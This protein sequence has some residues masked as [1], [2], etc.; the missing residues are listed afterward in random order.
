MLRQSA[1]DVDEA[2]AELQGYLNVLNCLAVEP[3]NSVPDVIIWML[4]ADKRTAYKR[5]PAYD[6]LY[7]EKT[8]GRGR[9]C[10]NLQTLYLEYP[11]TKSD[12]VNESRGVPVQLRIQLWLG[13]DKDQDKFDSQYAGGEI[14]TYAETY[15]NQS[16]V[17]VRG[18]GGCLTRPDFSDLTGKMRLNKD[19]F[20]VF[21]KEFSTPFVYKTF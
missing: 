3:Q 5:I 6:L 16:K 11:M 21:F 2:L 14:A 18:W 12:S 4:V 19:S 9:Q 8:E 15:E 20:Q 7:S 13:L 1:T 17:P 10:G